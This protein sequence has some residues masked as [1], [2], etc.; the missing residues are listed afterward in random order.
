MIKSVITIVIALTLVACASA[1]KKFNMADVDAMI[2]GQ[3][4]IADAKT[5]LGPPSTEAVGANGNTQLG[6]GYSSA[7][8]LG[9]EV[10][11]VVILFDSQGK[12][13]RVAGKSS[14]K[15]N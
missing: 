10:K 4:T 7:S 12:M 11:T 13:I 1:G 8:P 9:A 5:T 14:T 6:W 15:S 3:T 2:P